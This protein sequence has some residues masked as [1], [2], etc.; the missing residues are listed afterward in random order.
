MK[1]TKQHILIFFIAVMLVVTACGGNLLPEEPSP[2]P[3]P[4]NLD[5]TNDAGENTAVATPI[6]Q[7]PADSDAGGEQPDGETDDSAEASAATP[8]AQETATSGVE[9]TPTL[10]PLPK[11]ETNPPTQ[12]GS[13]G[14]MPATTR[15]L[16]FIGD[17]ALKLLT[18]QNRQLVELYP[19]GNPPAGETRT[20][21]PFRPY[22]G[23]ITHYDVSADGNRIVAARVTASKTLTRTID[24]TSEVLSLP[25]IEHEVFFLDVVS[26]ET[27]VLADT[28]T[29]LQTVTVA[30]N[31]QSVAFIGSGLASN[32]N[33]EYNDDLPDLNV[34]TVLTPDRGNLR[35]IASCTRFCHTLVWHP[36]SELFFYADGEALWLYNLSASNPQALLDNESADGA[37]IRIYSPISF[38]SNGRF[39]LMWE[40]RLEGGSRVVYDIP[41]QQ[42]IPV[43]DS[44][45]Y[46]DPYPTEVVWMPDTRLL[47]TRND[48]SGA[49]LSA[50]HEL[51]RINPDDGTIN[52]EETSSPGQNAAAA[53]T[54]NLENGRFAYALVNQTD[55]NVSGLYL[56]TS[57]TEPNT[58][59]NGVVPGFVSPLVTW[60]PDGSSAVY[61][62][63]NTPYFAEVNGRLFDMSPVFGSV[64]KDFTW[65]PPTAASR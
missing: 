12:A 32:P 56:Q 61:I 58:R 41:T 7:T 25:Y 10:A 20:N 22:V 57:F 1:Q 43:P 2:I 6:A 34:Y 38:A 46:A 30:P 60:S 44:F 24:G 8:L 50:A 9:A 52:L 28:V 18:H 35:E 40:G 4:P 29:D 59:I 65:L 54:V 42:L 17:G 5:E 45:V 26:K 37:N 33:P 62:Q 14:S 53:S 47:I 27:W 31:Q 49:S 23:D 63:H 16:V 48:V 21:D 39:L 19:G 36:T 15:D 64:V 11:I 51:W 13:S 55:P 3:P